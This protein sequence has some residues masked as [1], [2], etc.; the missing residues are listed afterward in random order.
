MDS[1]AGILEQY[2]GAKLLYRPARLQKRM[3]RYDNSVL[4]CSKTPALGSLKTFTNSVSE[5]ENS[6][7]A[8]FYI[9]KA[10]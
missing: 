10:C 5:Q 3:G 8:G 2:M 4:G 9:M 1:Y 6:R 7:A